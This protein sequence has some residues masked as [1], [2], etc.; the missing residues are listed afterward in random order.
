MKL[1]GGA[2]A[3]AGSLGAIVFLIILAMKVYSTGAGVALSVA[4]FVPC[5]G[6]IVMLV[7][8]GKATSILKANGIKV[9]LLGASPSSVP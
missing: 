7:V 4:A 9:G 3:L 8:S 1:L 5:L 6:L 2:V